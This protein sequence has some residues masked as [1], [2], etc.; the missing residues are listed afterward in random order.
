MTAPAVEYRQ[1]GR[2]KESLDRERVEFRADPEWI[3]RVNTE[4][5]RLGLNLSSFIR[6]IVTQHMDRVEDER[7]DSKARRKS[8]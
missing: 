1:V 2:K 6:M 8:S 3:E 5:L 7:A 4:A